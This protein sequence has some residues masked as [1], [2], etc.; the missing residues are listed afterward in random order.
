VRT[1]A[2]RLLVAVTSCLCVGAQAAAPA[3]EL[4][5]YVNEACVVADE[6]WLVPA[7]PLGE[8]QVA[9]AGP[10][11][12]LVVGKLAEVLISHTIKAS[13]GRIST[14]AERKDT[15]YAFARDT[16]L[17]RVDFN[18]QPTLS[19]NARLGCI[20]LVAAVFSKEANCHQQYQPR[21]PAAGFRGKPEHSWQATRADTSVTNVLRRSN[22]C[23]E[24]APRAVYEARFEF[25]SDGTAWRLVDAG[26]RVDRL[27]TSPEKRSERNVFYTLEVLQPTGTVSRGESLTMGL[28][29]LGKVK[30]GSEGA[31][32]A[33]SGPW[34]RVP[35]LNVEARRNYEQRTSLLQETWSEIG[36]LERAMKRNEIVAEEVRQRRAAANGDLA[37]G[38]AAEETRLAVQQVTLRAELGARRAEYAALP[39]QS[40]EFM[41][42]A[43]EIGLTETRSEQQALLVLANVMKQSSGFISST[44]GGQIAIAA[45]SVDAQAPLP[46]IV[47]EEDPGATLATARDAWHDARIAHRI[48][49][50]PDERQFADAR[51]AQARNNYEA[52]RRA[53]GLGELVR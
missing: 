18:P 48:A 47:L 11:T 41:P 14:D 44:A 8:D 23:V 38:L 34:L 50:T 17:Y 36:A 19:L 3:P 46:S 6:P 4:R 9:R 33:G 16:N 40:L 49:E 21:E 30:A 29:R 37:K 32:G 24:G 7:E 43:I 31:E 52:Q 27:L 25:S 13:A 22:I 1:A 45:R 39:R 10:I 12:A 20:T 2:S 28:V 53:L 26:Y 51:L 15:R 42:V 35:P 5:A